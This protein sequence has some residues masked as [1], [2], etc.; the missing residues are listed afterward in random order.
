MANKKPRYQSEG[1]LRHLEVLK[2]DR[3]DYYLSFKN[4][5]ALNHISVPD[6]ETQQISHGIA[7]T[8]AGFFK[9]TQ[10]AKQGK[11]F[12]EIAEYRQG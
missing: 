5:Q 9:R 3:N 2:A 7:N 1:N 12:L 8:T 10:T 6:L 4:R 11:T